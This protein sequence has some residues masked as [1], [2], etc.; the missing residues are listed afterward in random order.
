MQ[1]DGKKDEYDDF[2]DDLDIDDP[3][4]EEELDAGWDDLDEEDD[5]SPAT[6]EEEKA[7]KAAP[8]KKSFLQKNF[9]LVVAAIVLT[10]GGLLILPALI[11][12]SAPPVDS[13]GTGTSPEAVSDAAAIDE[14]QSGLPPMPAP[15]DGQAAEET[16]DEAMPAS[17][18][19]IPMPEISSAEMPLAE[20]APQPQ[21][22][23][24][25]DF[26]LEPVQE[27]AAETDSAVDAPLLS[28]VSEDSLLT[29]E[30]TDSPAPAA[31]LPLLS[32][33]NDAPGDIQDTLLQDA[34]APSQIPSVSPA[35]V[36]SSSESAELRK[37]AEDAAAKAQEA[38]QARKLAEEKV[39]RLEESVRSSEQTIEDL[40]KTVESLKKDLTAAKSEA[41]KP[42]PAAEKP[43]KTVPEPEKAPKAPEKTTPK[44]PTPLVI[45]PVV[46]PGATVSPRQE[47]PFQEERTFSDTGRGWVLRSA[48]PGRAVI[49]KADTN[50][51][52]N[53]AVG[54]TVSG[55][56][57]IVSI[58]NEGGRWVVRGTQ[59]EVSR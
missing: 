52:Q 4:G 1:D 31:E 15:M 50:D 58:Q 34:E 42:L 44:A 35:P 55:L 39:A 26:V 20:T 19:L 36:I 46:D 9:S 23:E 7:A 40:E 18:P 51:L 30:Q 17:G 13:G 54:D 8:A 12:P 59:G 33:S 22:V 57:R 47:I 43:V 48:Q 56:G 10:G 45:A 16:A 21:P 11:G 29:G 3:D 27:P 41:G 53:V 49:A 32:G 37:A 24:E 14:L 6:A 28:D 38:E 2:E 5:V 25:T